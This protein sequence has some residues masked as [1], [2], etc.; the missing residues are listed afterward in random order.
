MNLMHKNKHRGDGIG[1]C[2]P[3]TILNGELKILVKILENSVLD[4][5][6]SLEQTCHKGPDD[7][8]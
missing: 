1:N 6:V 5:L 4:R 3:Q 8:S 7:P 2:W